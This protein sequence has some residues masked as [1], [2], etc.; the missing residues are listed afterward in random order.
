MKSNKKHALTIMVSAAVL[1]TGM[2]QAAVSAQEAAKLGT[3]L[4]PVG[5]E[6]AGNAAGTIPAWEGGI[7]RP[8][9]G[10]R[11]GTFH[12]DPFAADKPLYSVTRANQATYA[13]VLTAGQK[14]MFAKYPTFRMDVYP[15]R[16]SAS[17]PQR[18]YEFSKRNATQCR[19]VA[20]G[21]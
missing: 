20:D 21:E 13:N 4:T 15:T 3:T 7:V 14:A 19:L 9:A 18:T 5:A 12:L 2:A 11:V 16:R 6:K 1:A 8:P 10:F 17:F